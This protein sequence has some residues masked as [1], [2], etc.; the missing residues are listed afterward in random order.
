[1]EGLMSIER[2]FDV[3]SFEDFYTYKSILDKLP[4]DINFFYKYLC[5]SKLLKKK[6]IK[7][8]P[9]V[10]S[11]MQAIND[12]RKESGEDDTATE[13]LIDCYSRYFF[14]MNYY[15]NKEYNNSIDIPYYQRDNILS[16][17]DSAFYDISSDFFEYSKSNEQKVIDFRY[18]IYKEHPLYSLEDFANK[19]ADV[20]LK[21]EESTDFR[22][23]IFNKASEIPEYLLKNKNGRTLFC[24]LFL[25]DETLSLNDRYRLLCQDEDLEST[26]KH[27]AIFDLLTFFICGTGRL[28]SIELKEMIFK[29]EKYDQCFKSLEE[30]HNFNAGKLV[31]KD[32]VEYSRKDTVSSDFVRSYDKFRQWLRRSKMVYNNFYIT[33]E[34]N[35]TRGKNQIKSENS[36]F[37]KASN[38]SVVYAYK[39]YCSMKIHEEYKILGNIYLIKKNKNEHFT[40]MEKIDLKHYEEQKGVFDFYQYKEQY[41]AEILKSY[42][43]CE[44]LVKKH[45]KHVS[46]PEYAALNKFIYDS[47]IHQTHSDNETIPNNK[48]IDKFHNLIGL[49]LDIEL[50]FEYVNFLYSIKDSA[51]ENVLEQLLLLEK[52]RFPLLYYHIYKS[53]ILPEVTSDIDIEGYCKYICMEYFDISN[54][55]HG[56]GSYTIDNFIESGLF[57]DNWL[58][59]FIEIIDILY[60]T[61]MLYNKKRLFENEL[62]KMDENILRSYFLSDFKPEEH[63]Y[64]MEDDN[65]ILDELPLKFGILY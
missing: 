1:M 64:L 2:F 20:V 21:I 53:L 4:I 23:F 32:D 10:L 19:A 55:F 30:L 45:T 28:P 50:G 59:D 5:S 12:W 25:I 44:K 26:V 6:F 56:Y 22:D 7:D 37:G 33:N 14:E 43:E 48:V 54:L 46:L 42:N 52:L 8:Y 38:N 58:D 65:N 39:S 61:I 16:I 27:C 15:K 63:E 57:D 18:S 24:I 11:F 35:R 41:G 31:T 17:L 60:P 3:K 51:E 13:L 62:S 40:K 47:I 36:Q 49:N 9:D 34:T 29:L